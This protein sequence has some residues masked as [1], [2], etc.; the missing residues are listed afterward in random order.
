MAYVIFDKS[1]YEMF[2]M[3]PKSLNLEYKR[4]SFRLIP[5]FLACG[6]SA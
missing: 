4:K 3:E 1:L 6:R 2:P 5:P